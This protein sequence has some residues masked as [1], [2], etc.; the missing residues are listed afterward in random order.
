M[1]M[2]QTAVAILLGAFLLDPASAGS[3][4][5]VVSLAPS[6]TQTVRHL[7]ATD[8]LVAVTPFCE[9]SE[10][11]VRVAGGIQPEAEAVLG[12]APDLV[13][14]TSMTPAATRQ[15]LARLGLRVEVIN[16]DSLG[17]I[18]E[19]QQKLADLLG[20]AAPTMPEA[21]KPAGN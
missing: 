6:L 18:R 9:A 16:A 5:R 13:L 19:A 11:I 2:P 4:A 21:A 8:R 14:A 1:T 7:G 15:Q 17:G 20:V 10:G 3:P 12:L